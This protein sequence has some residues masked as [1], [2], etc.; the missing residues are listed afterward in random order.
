MFPWINP[1]RWTRKSES[2]RISSQSADGIDVAGMVWHSVDGETFAGGGAVKWSTTMATDRRPVRRT[3]GPG[4]RGGHKDREPWGCAENSEFQDCLSA[5]KFRDNTRYSKI[6]LGWD[7]GI[8]QALAFNYP[9]T[10]LHLHLLFHHSRGP[11]GLTRNFWK[12]W[13][14]RVGLS[15]PKKIEVPPEFWRCDIE[16]TE[17][18][19][20][21]QWNSHLIGVMIINHYMGLSENVGYIPNEIAIFHRDNDQQNHWL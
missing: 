5:I 4:P 9:P 8:F 6:G 19:V 15:L 3:P 1:L 21:S 16:I 20:Y 7:Q 12:M 14:V 13:T 18:R 10:N 11:T 17:N 2:F